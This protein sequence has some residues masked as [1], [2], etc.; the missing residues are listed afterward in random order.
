LPF[1]FR[2]ES[3]PVNTLPSQEGAP[4]TFASFNHVRKLTTKVLSTWARIL[5]AVP[6]SRLLIGGVDDGQQRDRITT[7]LTERGIAPDR[8]LF[9]PR[10]RAFDYLE[11]HH[12]VDL[13][14][15]AFPYPSATTIQ[16]ALWMGVPTIT[17]EGN[18]PVSRAGAGSM[19]HLDLS[20]FIAHSLDDY[21]SKAIYAAQR[22]ELLSELRRELRQK[23]TN[24]EQGRCADIAK[25]LHSALKTM[26]NRYCQNEPAGSFIA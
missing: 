26:W 5:A 19:R 10:C 23:L 4:F 9:C 16:H 3:P 24:S 11:L 13:C 20:Q 15:D 12:Q 14:L 17:L 1:E 2:G 8:L 18:T 6:N 22:P 25:S 7:A 21:V